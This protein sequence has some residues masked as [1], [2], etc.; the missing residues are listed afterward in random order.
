MQ[1]DRQKSPQTALRQEI[2]ALEHELRRVRDG[3]E[4][5]R[6]PELERRA[7][8]LRDNIE[9]CRRELEAGLRSARPGD[10]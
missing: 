4:R 5:N 10:E 8:Q 6:T 9:L 3:L 2:A 7:R 1:R